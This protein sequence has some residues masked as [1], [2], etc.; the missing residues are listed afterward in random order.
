MSPENICLEAS[1]TWMNWKEAQRNDKQATITRMALVLP[2]RWPVEP[3][4]APPPLPL[5]PPLCFLPVNISFFVNQMK[6]AR[7][8]AAGPVEAALF[9]RATQVRE[10]TFEEGAAGGSR[11]H[12]SSETPNLMVGTDRAL[13]S[14]CL[15]QRLPVHGNF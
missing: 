5:P 11:L 9:P 8:S 12:L 15:D 14:G 10:Q 1:S 3:T 13:Y 6:K 7:K 4:L 2:S